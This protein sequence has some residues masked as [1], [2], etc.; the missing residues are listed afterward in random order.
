MAEDRRRVLVTGG[1]R[2][3]GLAIAQKLAGAG[4]SVIAVARQK[5]KEVAA[6]IAERGRAGTGAIHFR[7]F[8][9]G[10]IDGIPDLVRGLQGV[11]PTVRPGQ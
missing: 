7:P 5:S 2:G 9:L 6:A 10:N 4:Y 3:L 8:D 11:R 1:S